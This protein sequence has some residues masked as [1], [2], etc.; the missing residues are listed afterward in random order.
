MNRI[1][2]SWKLGKPMVE[3]RGM[4]RG[5][6]RLKMCWH[7]KEKHQEQF[8]WRERDADVRGYSN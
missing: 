6:S 3:A 8:Q 1:G 2:G 7:G 4:R 5:M